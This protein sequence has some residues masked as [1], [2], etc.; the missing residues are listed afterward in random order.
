M[1]HL[2]DVALSLSRVHEVGL[3]EYHNH[4]ITCNLSYHKTLKPECG[5]VEARV[6][7]RGEGEGGMQR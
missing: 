3:V 6:V 1:P 2:A 4:V 5:G 7:C